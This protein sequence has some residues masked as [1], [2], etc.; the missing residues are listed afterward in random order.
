MAG[1]MGIERLGGLIF[2]ILRGFSYGLV[3][4]I[5]VH[6]LAGFFNSGLVYDL[7]HQSN[8]AT[9]FYDSGLLQAIIW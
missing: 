4:A 3:V 9:L 6:N 7:Y 1:L 2:T 8:L 5:I